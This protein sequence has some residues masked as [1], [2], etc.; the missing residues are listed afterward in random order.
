MLRGESLCLPLD[1][2]QLHCRLLPAD[3]GTPIPTLERWKAEAALAEKKV[4]QIFEFQSQ[5][6]NWGPWG[7]KAEILQTAP[8][9]PAHSEEGLMFKT[10]AL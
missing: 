10:S 4:I 6:S 1:G 2:A 9:V 8:T 3:V 5:G 7:K